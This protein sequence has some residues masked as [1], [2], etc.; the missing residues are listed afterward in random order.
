MQKL[1]YSLEQMQELSRALNDLGIKGIEQAKIMVY[2]AN[3]IDN[4][5]KVIEGP[6][7]GIEHGSDTSN[8]DEKGE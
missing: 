5:L 1:V 8:G 4:P 6:M 2:A 7:E 3:I